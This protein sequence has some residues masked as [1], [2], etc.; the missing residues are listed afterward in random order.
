MPYQILLKISVE[1]FPPKP[2]A[3][4]NT[5]VTGAFVTVRIGVKFVSAIEVEKFKFGKRMPS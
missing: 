2:N 1:L 3:L 4:D 5:C